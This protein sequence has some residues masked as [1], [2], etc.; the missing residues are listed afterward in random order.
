MPSENPAA[1]RDDGRGKK[2]T[3]AL[4]A[5]A[6]RAKRVSAAANLV[7]QQ[8]QSSAPLIKRYLNKKE[9][10]HRIGDFT[11]PTVWRWMREGTFP[12]AFMVGGKL[13][14]LEHE[15]NAWIDAQSRAA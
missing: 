11:Y 8:G 4:A 10:L 6:R 5:H 2:S 14:W 3:P 15:I 12:Q 9:V 7:V 13:V 1:D